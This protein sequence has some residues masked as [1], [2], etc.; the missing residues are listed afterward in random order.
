MA[1]K[2]KETVKEHGTMARGE[3]EPV[4]VLPL[5]VPGVMPQEFCPEHI[6]HCRVSHGHAGMA[7]VCLLHSVSREHPDRINAELV[8]VHLLTRASNMVLSWSSG[9][10][11]SL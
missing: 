9:R 7:R 4:A 6:G 11:Y 5:R 8:K 3:D 10:K 2:M 1:G